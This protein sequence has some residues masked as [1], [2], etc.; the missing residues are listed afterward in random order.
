MRIEI[1]DGWVR[2]IFYLGSAKKVGNRR[3]LGDATLILF[4][5]SSEFDNAISRGAKETAVAKCRFDQVANSLWCAGVAALRYLARELDLAGL[6]QK[7]LV[8]GAKVMIAGES[9]GQVHFLQI[10]EADEPKPAINETK[11]QFRHRE[12][13]S[14]TQPQ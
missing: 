10:V 13:Q 5:F 3:P 12:E 7:L 9:S 1:L 4:L 14:I 2:N 8:D 11:I 6:K